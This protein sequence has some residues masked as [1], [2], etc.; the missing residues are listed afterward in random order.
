MNFLKSDPI[1]SPESSVSLDFAI[2]R[3]LRCRPSVH[4]D[5][6]TR[7]ALRLLLSDLDN[8]GDVCVGSAGMS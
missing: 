1:A 4:A 7:G 5:D 6:R 3:M 2:N 8:P